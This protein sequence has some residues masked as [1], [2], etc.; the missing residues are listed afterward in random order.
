MKLNLI[1]FALTAALAGAAIPT[2]A[3]DALQQSAPQ[4][5]SLKDGTTVYIFKDGKMAREDKFGQPRVFKK[6]EVLE[7]A[8]GRKLTPVG[9]EVARLD[10]LLRDGHQN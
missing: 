7:T 4:A 3:R 1:A 10:S 9:N 8:D 2:F 6:N 5:V